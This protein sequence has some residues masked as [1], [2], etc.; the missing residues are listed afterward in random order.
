MGRLQLLGFSSFRIYFWE[1]HS[2]EGRDWPLR[3]WPK[4]VSESPNSFP[5]PNPEGFVLLLLRTCQS[6]TSSFLFSHLSLS[7]SNPGKKKWR[8]AHQPRRLFTSLCFPARPEQ[9]AINSALS[10]SLL[11]SSLMSSLF[12]FLSDCVFRLRKKQLPP[13][14]MRRQ[15][16]SVANSKHN[17][18]VTGP[19]G[20]WHLERPRSRGSCSDSLRN[21]AWP[22]LSQPRLSCNESHR[23]PQS[24]LAKNLL[25]SVPS[26]D[27][28]FSFQVWGSLANWLESRGWRRNTPFPFSKQLSGIFFF[29]TG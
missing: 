22:L 18:I 17:M 21:S 13:S 20:P 26:P 8:K 4:E 7:T 24:P 6:F 28:G 10:P 14:S 27:K 1:H 19:H 3:E 11:S 9:A 16:A 23:K 5:L 2:E 12:F 25:K 15:D 29:P